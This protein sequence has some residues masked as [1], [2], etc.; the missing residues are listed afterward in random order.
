[1]TKSSVQSGH[2]VAAAAYIVGY[3]VLMEPFFAFG[4][5]EF[6]LPVVGIEYGLALLFDNDRTATIKACGGGACVPYAFAHFFVPLAI[7]WWAVIPRLFDEPPFA[8][9]V[10]PRTSR[11]LHLTGC[12]V[13]V[14]LCAYYVVAPLAGLFADNSGLFDYGESWEYMPGVAL[15]E[16]LSYFVAACLATRHSIR[17]REWHDPSGFFDAVLAGD[18]QAVRGQLAA[19]ADPN[20]VRDEDGATALHLAVRAGQL[21]MLT[22]LLALP[23]QSRRCATMPAPRR[24]TSRQPPTTSTRSRRCSTPA[25]IPTCTTGTRAARP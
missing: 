18:A 4:V 9:A 5:F 23:K 19:G 21:E 8:T 17:I 1:M 7:V 13:L 15:A 12:L 14:P 3:P 24:C 22:M 6:L 25:P 2:V 20:V 16:H 11:F 10:H